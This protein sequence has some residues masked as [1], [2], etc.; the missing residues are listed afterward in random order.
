MFF[1]RILGLIAAATLVLAAASPAAAQSQPGPPAIDGID[2]V[3]LITKQ[4]APG[5]PPEQVTFEAT[6]NYRL[7]SAQSGF[8]LL[9]LFENSSEEST[10]QST[11][12]I[13]AN[14]GSGK[15]VLSI[16]HTLGSD[17][18]TLTL[19]AGLFKGDQKLVAWVSTNPIDMG[20]WP[21]RVAFEQ[22]MAARLDNN[23]PNAEQ[24]L[25]TAIEE[26]PDTGNYYYWRADTRVRME[27]FDAA[28]ADFS[29]SIEL[30]P[31][32]RA[33]RVGRGVSR[34]WL[35]Q[36]QGAVDD[37]SIAIGADAKPDRITAWGYRA[38]GLAHA[39]LGAFPAAVADYQ[40]YLELAPTATDRAQVEG[41]IKDIS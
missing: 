29:R 3:G 39:A 5:S 27:Q 37:L 36:A 6:V 41:W 15:M 34:L 31:Q 32:D 1:Q 38:R 24:F 26:S 18:K 40:A 9:F 23:L 33:S 4:P 16:D 13:P 25:T 20:P 30:M 21:G 17:V 8:V 22:A 11:N 19:V 7:Q 14:Q 12:G 35:G 10:Q 28:V 2:L